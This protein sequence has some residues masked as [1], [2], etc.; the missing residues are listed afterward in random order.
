MF[1]RSKTPICGWGSWMDAGTADAVIRRFLTYENCIKAVIGAWEH[2]GQMHASPYA[3]SA[4]KTSPTLP[5]Q[6]AEMMRFFDRYLRE[7]R[8]EAVERALYYYTMGEEVWKQ[9]TIWPPEGI[10]Y[11]SWYLGKVNTLTQTMAPSE[12]ESDT[13]Q[14]DYDSST[15]NHNRWWELGPR[16][17]TSSLS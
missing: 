3:P 4:W 5:D 11:E 9:T 14:L 8:S 2:G 13:Y 7:N 16:Q 6:W 17:E 15:G 12:M 1:A 10:Q